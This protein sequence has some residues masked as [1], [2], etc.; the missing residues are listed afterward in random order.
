MTYGKIFGGQGTA[1]PNY[2][3]KPNISAS[4]PRITPEAWLNRW[5]VREQKTAAEIAK[6]LGVDEAEVD[7]A[8]RARNAPWQWTAAIKSWHVKRRRWR[9]LHNAAE[10]R[11]LAAK[12]TAD[13]RKTQGNPRGVCRGVRRGDQRADSLPLLPPDCG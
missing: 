9:D 12:T 5:Q 13:T 8:L 3:R 1:A 10:R 6:I 11:R 2:T 4:N 7:H